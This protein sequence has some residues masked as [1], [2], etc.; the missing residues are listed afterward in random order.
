MKKTLND[1]L[2]RSFLSANVLDDLRRKLILG[3]IQ[4]GCKL[5]E[6]QIA[7][8]MNVS[9]GPVRNALFILE[10]EG[11]ISFLSNGRTVALGFSLSDAEKLYETRF[12]LETKA[13][14]LVCN[15]HTRNFHSLN[16]IMDQLKKEINR[17]E[18]FTSLDIAYHHELMNLSGN[19]FLVQCW[20]TLRPMIETILSI[21]NSHYRE[22]NEWDKGYVLKL[23]E[24]I[25]E[26]L[27][28]GDVYVAVSLIREHLESAKM[29]MMDKLRKL[30]K[31]DDHIS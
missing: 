29:I 11:L 18:K 3:E 22:N 31:R 15:N 5:V 6:I 1:S 4:A 12:Y 30:I 28:L 24:R 23:H 7:A 2:D 16:Q 13:V 9:R 8:E 21:T 20:S 26:A 17:V 10:K 25:N 19:K 14:E 27:I